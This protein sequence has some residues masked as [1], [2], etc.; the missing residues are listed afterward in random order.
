MYTISN[1]GS[2]NITIIYDIGTNIYLCICEYICYVLVV[3]GTV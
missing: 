1:D 2:S 3:I